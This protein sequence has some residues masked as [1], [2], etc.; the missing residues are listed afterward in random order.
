MSVIKTFGYTDLSFSNRLH[1]MSD[2]LY[3]ILWRHADDPS[4]IL[5]WRRGQIFKQERLFPMLPGNSLMVTSA[6]KSPI[7]ELSLGV[8][9]FISLH[10][11]EKCPT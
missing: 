8:R 7:K 5:L 11:V 9:F 6:Y 1:S 3:P 2:F 4:M 10:G